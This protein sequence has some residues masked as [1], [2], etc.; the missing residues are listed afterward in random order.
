MRHFR[1]DVEPRALTDYKREGGSLYVGGNL[2]K[3]D[4]QKQLL[5]EQK[6]LCAYCMRRIDAVQGNTPQM[7]IEHVKCRDLY[8]ALQLDYK[9]MLGVCFGGSDNPMYKEHCDKSKDKGGNHYE[10]LKLNPLNV[11]V[12]S[13]FYFLDTGTIK[14]VNDD[15]AVVSDICALNLNEEFTRI[16]REKIIIKLKEAYKRVCRKADKSLVKKFIDKEITKWKRLNNK[17]Y[18]Q[19]YNIIAIKFLEKKKNSRLYR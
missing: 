12:E 1:K 10:L 7:I 4:I 19:P 8:P 3:S 17:G 15:E 2:D 5:K 18:L 16:N 14:A 9:N 13:L 6:G 11:N